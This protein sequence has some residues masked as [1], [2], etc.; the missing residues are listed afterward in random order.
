MNDSFELELS[1]I[2]GKSHFVW[3][4]HPSGIVASLKI[5]CLPGRVK[6]NKAI[7]VDNECWSHA[8]RCFVLGF[9]VEVVIDYKLQ[10]QN[11]TNAARS[12][13]EQVVRT[14]DF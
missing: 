7:I 10:L 11:Q 12:T 6:H 14:E 1:Y 13:Q 3:L 4:I 5:C 9:V 8:F 2:S